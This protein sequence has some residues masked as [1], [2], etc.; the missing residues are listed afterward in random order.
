MPLLSHEALLRAL[1][2]GR[3]GG[4]F[5]LYGA[6]EFLV[7]EA[8]AAVVAAHLEPTTRDFN[9]DQLRASE[10]AP[11][12]LASVLHTPPL[13]AEWRVVVLREAQLLASA[14]R[15]RAAVEAVLE[16]PVP[17]LALVLIAHIPERSRA[18]FYERL[19]RQAVAVEYDTLSAGDVPGWLVERARTEGVELEPSTAR[20][21]A[22]A[23][24]PQLARLLME[25]RKLREYVGSRGRIAAADVEAVVGRVP[26]QNRWDWFDLVG[27]GR[28]REARAT[29]TVLL[30]AGESGVGL[31]LGLGTHFLRLAIAATS[32]QK[33]LE[34]ELPAHQRWLAAR[35]AQQARR[36]TPLALDAALDDLLRADRLLKS[37][38]LTEE[39]ILD[40]LLLR[41]EGRTEAAA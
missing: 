1:A 17:G 37:A 6:E 23:V 30:D 4:A 14:A 16:R 19:K 29:L 27:A 33:A 40:E 39:Q 34:A 11:E 3:R 35:I 38:S 2:E 20:A 26:Q 13:M 25:L 24:G 21:L 41:L 31:V 32:G 28:F 18:Q 15:L 5:F 10:V 22:S 7:E 9:L 8:A 12:Q 36:W